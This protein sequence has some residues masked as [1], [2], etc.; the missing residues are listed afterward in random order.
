[1]PSGPLHIRRRPGSSSEG[2]IPDAGQ[3]AIPRRVASSVNGPLGRPILQKSFLPLN[4]SIAT[5]QLETVP[6]TEA[7]PVSLPARKPTL[8]VVDDE[9]GPRLSLQVIFDDRYNVV[10]AEDGPS[11]IEIAKNQRIDVAVL[12]IRM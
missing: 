1:M 4:M 8:L 6:I 3:S 11:A 2:S 12:D 10:L 5:A 7:L 9:Q